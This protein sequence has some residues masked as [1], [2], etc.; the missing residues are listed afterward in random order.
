GATGGSATPFSG[1]ETHLHL[2]SGALAVAL[3]LGLPLFAALAWVVWTQRRRPA[4]R[5][6]AATAFVALVCSPGILVIGSTTVPTPW[7]LARHVPFLR[8]VRPQRLTMFVWLIGAVGM[9]AWIAVRQG[10]WRRWGAAA[11]AAG[12]M[13]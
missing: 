9:G 10:S 13:L 7:T 12:A 1:V 11:V 4:V 8:L 5:A 6:L 3:G 2:H